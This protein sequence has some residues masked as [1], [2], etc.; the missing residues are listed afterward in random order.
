MKSKQALNKVALLINKA[1]IQELNDQGHRLTGAL[2]R[3]LSAFRVIDKSK[4][5]QLNGYALD[6][7]QDLETGMP[8]SGKLPSVAELQ[9]YFVLRGLSANKALQAAILTARRQAKE[10]MPTKASSRF[11]KTGER[12]KFISRTWR[13]NEQKVD[14]LIDFEI[15]NLFIDEYSKQKNETI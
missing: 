8:S 5:T 11:S 12:K 1:L 3:S 13:S 2:E 9:K 4:E 10:G 6:Y 14:S 15:N 7:A